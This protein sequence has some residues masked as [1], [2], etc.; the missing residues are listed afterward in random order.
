MLTEV[1]VPEDVPAAVSLIAA[2]ATIIGGGTLV[3]PALNNHGSPPTELVSLRRTG[4]AGITVTGSTVTIGAT[5]TLA[6]IEHDPR[7]AILHPV[8]RSIA[9]VPVRTL[10][11]VGGNLFARQPYGD[12]A[13]ALVALNAKA[14]L[15]SQEAPVELPLGEHD[16]A[17]A[18][19]G[20]RAVTRAGL[21]ERDTARAGLGERDTA[22]AGLEERAP[23]TA[24]EERALV[25]AVTFE[26]TAPGAFRYLK[27]ARRRY[28]SASLVTVAATITEAG[29]VRVALGGVSD[30]VVRAV[31]VEQALA[32]RPL[33]EET[34]AAAAQAGL[35]ELSPAD[36][37]YASAW[38]RRRVFPVH[39]RRA[40]LGL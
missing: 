31:R 11:T 26:L 1:H 40:L 13:V 8:V 34:V 12:L 17:T 30:H 29:G 39:L 32:G 4:L 2:G 5:T 18:G 37:A 14:V 22:T 15:A 27:A 38:Y 7:L 19:L 16:P 21:E 23:V 24:A 9:S 35:T 28:N 3:M 33:T 36:D 10:A 25:T 20:K 6:Q